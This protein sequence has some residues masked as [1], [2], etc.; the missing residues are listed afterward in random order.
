MTRAL[1]KTWWLLAL[2]GVLDAMHAAINL[3]MLNPDSSLNLRNFALGAFGLIGVSPLVRGPL[4]FRPVSLLF[5]VM[6]VSIGAFAVGTAQT[7]QSDARE[8]WFLGVAGAASIGFA[9]SP[10]QLCIAVHISTSAEAIKTF[11]SNDDLL[12]IFF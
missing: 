6:A 3:V 10:L 1:I 9:F 8:R 11:C 7:R 5:L 2:C 4:S 12:L